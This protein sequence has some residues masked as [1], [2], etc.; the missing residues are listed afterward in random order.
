VTSPAPPPVD[1]PIIRPTLPPFSEVAADF[2]RIWSSGLLT[3]GSAV[4]RFEEAVAERCQ[5]QNAVAMSSCTSG[6]IL[7]QAAL[8]L[9]LGGEVL[10]PAFTFAATAQSVAWNGLVPVFADCDAETLTLDPEDAARRI[11]PR[12]VAILATTIFGTPPDLDALAALAADRGVPLL[13]DSAQA[14]GSSWHGRPLGGFGR[15]EVFSFSPTKVAT[16]VEA[17]IVSTSD[18]T[19]AQTLRQMRDYGKGRDGQDMEWFGLSAR[20]S[21]L[22]ATVGLAT[23]AHLD[24]YIAVRARGIER[25]RAGLSDL[26]GVGFPRLPAEARSSCNYM[27]VR[28]RRGACPL[29]RDEVYARLADRG[30][31]TKKYFYPAVHRQTAF[32]RRFGEPP[33]L[34]RAEAAAAECLAVPLYGHIRDDQIDRVLAAIRGLFA[35]A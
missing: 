29:Q 22:H 28:F 21:E 9:P 24:E 8:E 12:T 33:S 3:V 4:R 2:E 32:V 20:L 26:P 18:G 35:K 34:P 14:L 13:L 17:G 5:V 11:S 10:V 16:A 15:A 6:L 1:L 7:V 27:V 30:I 23:L 19:L 31:Q 25:Y